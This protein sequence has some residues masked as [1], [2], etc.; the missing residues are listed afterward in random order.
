[1]FISPRFTVQT[2]KRVLGEPDRYG[3]REESWEPPV[4]QKVYGWSPPGPDEEFVRASRDAVVQDLNVYVPPGFD[5][6]ADD[7]IVVGGLTYRA[8]GDPRDYNHGPFGFTPGLVVR[9]TRVKELG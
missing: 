2:Q 3:E 9:A 5:C 1:M 8:S 7:L 4:D 6:S